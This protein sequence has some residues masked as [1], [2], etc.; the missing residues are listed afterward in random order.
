[1]NDGSS[2]AWQPT[3]QEDEVICV[4][5]TEASYLQNVNEP[6][7]IP[8]LLDQF[9]N[10]IG[11]VHQGHLSVD[12]SPALNPCFANAPYCH[13]SSRSQVRMLTTAQA[14]APFVH[15]YLRRLFGPP[16]PISSL[17]AP[18]AQQ[19]PDGAPL[20]SVSS[21]R[22]TQLSAPMSNDPFSANQLGNTAQD[23]SLHTQ[24]PSHPPFPQPFSLSSTS[25][26]PPLLQ[27]QHTSAASMGKP[28]SK[29]QADPNLSDDERSEHLDDDNNSD[30]DDAGGDTQLT[31]GVIIVPEPSK[32]SRAKNI[33]SRKK[34]SV[35]VYWATQTNLSLQPV[36]DQII[37]DPSLK[38]SRLSLIDK[39]RRD[40]YKKVLNSEKKEW[41]KRTSEFNGAPFST[42]TFA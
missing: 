12:V 19:A 25:G 4:L 27:Q 13:A 8:T 10:G 11:A 29:R 7:F 37:A 38:S 24:P 23:F 34:M 1:M 9:L 18:S 33:Y 15:P 30:E 35:P 2:Q 32:R 22:L 40:M 14:F 36:D 39:Y 42:M 41:K 3:P 20:F 6:T 5:V 28:S 21:N 26:Q 16:Q 31:E 17:I